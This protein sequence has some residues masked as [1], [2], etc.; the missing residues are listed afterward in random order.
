MEYFIHWAGFVGAWLLVAGPLVQAALELRDENLDRDSLQSV[1]TDV[2]EPKPISNWWWLL[3]P[4]AYLK[5]RRRSQKYR[6]QW[7]RAMTREQ[8]EQMVGFSNK[9]TGW[10]FVAGGAFLIFMKEAWEL[11]ELYRLP[12]FIY[13]IVVV[14]LAIAAVANTVARLSRSD[15]I[16]HSDDPD[17]AAKKRA[18]RDAALAARNTRRKPKP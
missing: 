10:F 11:T 12:T 1:S 18:E 2:P 9:A 6:E 7:M 3:P 14:A 15:E 17:Y 13:W 16:I 4:V 8:R 5:N